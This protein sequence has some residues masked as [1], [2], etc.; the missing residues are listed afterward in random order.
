MKKL[1]LCTFALTHALAIHSMNDGLK[2]LFNAPRGLADLTALPGVVTRSMLS[3]APQEPALVNVEIIDHAADQ[4]S[5]SDKKEE[6][7][8]ND[9]ALV[10]SRPAGL[11]LHVN[12]Y[13]S[14]N[15]ISIANPYP[16][17]EGEDTW[18]IITKH[19]AKEAKVLETAQN[20][21][22]Q[23]QDLVPDNLKSS[24]KTNLHN[25]ENPLNDVETARELIWACL[26]RT[27][28]DFATSYI[29]T[30]EKN[31]DPCRRFD[32]A[33]DASKVYAE[34][35]YDN[36][37]AMKEPNE[38]FAHLIKERLQ[39]AEEQKDEKTTWFMRQFGFMFRDPATKQ[40]YDAYLKGGK[41]ALEALKI[42]EAQKDAL[43]E[44]FASIMDA[45]QELKGLQ[46]ELRK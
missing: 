12:D 27:D 18:D 4:P 29:Q 11:R 25:S 17:D 23:A 20:V 9:Q 46:K 31:F 22:K 24:I 40:T 30:L 5:S 28:A 26:T 6:Q 42:P 13:N 37:V 3:T 44:C 14:W 39:K 21:L 34:F 41:E 1:L 36:E 35:A 7:T 16:A 45:K 10:T 2:A 15:R 32:P 38:T 8:S 43:L 19:D 33:F